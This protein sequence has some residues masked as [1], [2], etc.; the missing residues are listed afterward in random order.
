MKLIIFGKTF[1][2]NNSIHN[3]IDF[4]IRRR[5]FQNIAYVAVGSPSAKQI[6]AVNP[7]EERLAGNS[8]FMKFGQGSESQY[9]VPTKLFEMYHRSIIPGVSPY[10]SII[11]LENDKF[12]MKKIAIFDKGMLKLELNQEES[13]VFNLFKRKIRLGSLVLNDD[14]SPIGIGIN[15]N[16]VKIKCKNSAKEDRIF[17][18][19]KITLRGTIEEIGKL[20]GVIANH[21]PMLEEEF[22][23]LL[24][25]QVSSL[26]RKFKEN[27]VDPLELSIVYWAH[28]KP[29]NFSEKWLKEMF[30]HAQF[31]INCRVILERGGNLR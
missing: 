12:V 9:S 27:K 19:I 20:Q 14:T 31:N 30:S 15:E 10:C 13:M 6:L 26:L 28:N 7:K 16:K 1:T 18:D 17:F 23:K 22:S 2:I 11:E 3:V 29:Y 24:N 21:K 25:K 4:F 5:D 8:L